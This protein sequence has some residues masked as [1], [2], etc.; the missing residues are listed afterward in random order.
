MKKIVNLTMHNATDSQIKDGVFEPS[1]K[2]KV[3][4]ALLFKGLPTKEEITE[5]AK[6]LTDVAISENATHAMIGGAPYLMGALEQELHERDITPLYSFTE[7][8]SVE[9]QNGDGTVTKTNI[10]EHIGFVEV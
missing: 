6:Q 3:K 2:E 7:R 9:T 8:K 5:K 10:F 4:E 1:N